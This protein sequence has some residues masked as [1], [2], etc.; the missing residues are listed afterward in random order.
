M[1][2]LISAGPTRENI[3]PV[4]YISNYSS[5]KMGYAIAEAAR[6]AGHEVSIV[7]GP[8]SI[9]APDGNIHTTFVTTAA[10][11]AEAMKL[12]A[13]DAD[14]II[15][16]AAVADYR[17]AACAKHKLK[18]NGDTLTLTLEP[19]E[20]I[21]ASLG[22]MKS[23]SQTLVGFA[24]ETRELLAHAKDKLQRKNLDWIVANDVS[25]PDRG[26]GSEQNAA[27]MIARNGDIIEF[28]LQSKYSLAA[29]IISIIDAARGVSQTPERL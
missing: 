21:L 7:S 10:E 24:A 28:P 18:K 6:D 1:K 16:T 11:M 15:M 12:A 17:P 22:K 25:L 9:Q 23:P 26:F 14:V 19:T 3:D 20:D 5:G 8:V 29:K 2:Y 13:P 27:T 4:R